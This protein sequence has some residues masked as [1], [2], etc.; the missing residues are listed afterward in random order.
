MDWVITITHANLT[1]SYVIH[2]LCGCGKSVDLR[3]QEI[4]RRNKFR[5]TDWQL[6]EDSDG[7]LEEADSAEETSTQSVT[8]IKKMSRKKKK[9][10]A[11]STISSAD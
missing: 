11:S 1:Y 9:K 5:K 6:V 4:V 7:S 3:I 8:K 2:R 10:S